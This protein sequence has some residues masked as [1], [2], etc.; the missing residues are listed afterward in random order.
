M[1]VHSYIRYHPFVYLIA[2]ILCI[3][4]FTI[5]TITVSFDGC[6]RPPESLA[7]AFLAEARTAELLVVFHLLLQLCSRLLDPPH[8]VHTSTTDPSQLAVASLAVLLAD[9]TPHLAVMLAHA[10]YAFRYILLLLAGSLS[11]LHRWVDFFS[12]HYFLHRLLFPPPSSFGHFGFPD[13]QVC[14]ERR[15]AF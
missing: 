3:H 10:L 12:P 2:N 1:N 9:L 7:H 15:S 6:A 13:F 8:C 14:E 4:I 11:F 5:I